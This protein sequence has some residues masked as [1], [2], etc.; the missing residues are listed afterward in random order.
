MCRWYDKVSARAKRDNLPFQ[1]GSFPFFL[2]IAKDMGVLCT[3]Q[4][5]LHEANVQLC[6]DSG[7]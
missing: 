6:R 2:V 4:G 1:K 7:F 5:R 3:C